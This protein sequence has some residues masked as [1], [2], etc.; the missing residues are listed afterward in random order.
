MFQLL[1][2]Q[3]ENLSGPEFKKCVNE[4]L[5]TYKQTLLNVATFGRHSFTFTV[6]SFETYLKDYV[7]EKSSIQIIQMIML[8][9]VLKSCSIITWFAS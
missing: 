7:I 1:K 6:K 4:E 3:L 2:K 8:I 5:E 9:A